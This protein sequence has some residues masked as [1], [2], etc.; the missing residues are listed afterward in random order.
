MRYGVDLGH[1]GKRVVRAAETAQGLV[2]QPDEPLRRVRAVLGL[3]TADSLFRVIELQG[4]AQGELNSALRWELQRFLPYPVDEGSFDYVPLPGGPEA[5]ERFLAVGARQDVVQQHITAARR[6]GVVAAAV[7]PEWATLWWAAV[8]LAPGGRSFGILDLGATAT[9]IVVISADGS[10]VVH[11]EEPIGGRHFSQAIV[12]ATGMS[13]EGAEWS[14]L[15]ELQ[16]ELGDVGQSEALGQLVGSLARVLRRVAAEQGRGIS[17]LVAVGGGGHWPALRATLQAALGVDVL[18]PSAGQGPL[19][20][21][22]CRMTLAGALALWQKG[23]S[24]T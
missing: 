3:P 10:P 18:E 6:Q 23:G 11:F 24:V 13:P 2:L 12:E 22:D 19:A 15:N 17:G 1:T 21:L 8:S 14:K 4:A 7:E 20:A 9:R 16:E 5:P